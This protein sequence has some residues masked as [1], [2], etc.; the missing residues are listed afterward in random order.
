MCSTPEGNFRSGTSVQH[1]LRIGVD[2]G[3]LKEMEYPSL[4][5]AERDPMRED[6]IA[7]FWEQVARGGPDEC[8]LWTGKVQKN[9]Y[10][11]TSDV[12][13]TSL[14]HRTAWL[15]THPGILVT[16][17]DVVRHTCD[18]RLCCNPAHLSCGTYLENS[19]DMVTKGRSRH[20]ENHYMTSLTD[21]V[22]R[23]IAH[24]CASEN[25]S[26]PLVASKYGVT[27]HWLARLMR[28]AVWGH[29]T[30]IKPV[31]LEEPLVSNC[32]RCGKEVVR[33]TLHAKSYC[34]RNCRQFCWRHRQGPEYQREQAQKLAAWRA[35]R[36]S[37]PQPSPD[38]QEARGERFMQAMMGRVQELKAE[39]KWEA[40]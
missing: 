12:A 34:S 4:T 21:K 30:G 33:R 19:Q 38:T 27:T 11:Q 16:R 5:D 37:E 17:N 1:R 24:L 10:G 8:W 7:S 26:R 36:R 18:V 15:L 29:V 32:P 13:G 35:A 9:G 3:I 22:V 39:G 20:G 14:A 2:F 23:D 6:R 31:K 25:L 28:G 40:L